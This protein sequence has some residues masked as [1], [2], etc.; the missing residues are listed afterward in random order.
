MAIRLAVAV[1]A[2]RWSGRRRRS[3]GQLVRRF[4]VGIVG[5]I[6]RVEVVG[7]HGGK[8]MLEVW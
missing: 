4:G 3:H 6:A 8:T 1:R 7:I 5:S 2:P